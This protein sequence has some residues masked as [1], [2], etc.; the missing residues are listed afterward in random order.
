MPGRH[1]PARVLMAED[2]I[3]DVELL[4]DELRE[5]GFLFE[6]RV[7][8]DE[9]DFCRELEEFKPHLVLSDLTMPGFSGYRALDLVRASAAHVPFIF[10]S[11]TIGE[12]AAIEA[13]KRGATDFVL[14]NNLARLPS[15]VR[16]A[17][18]DFEER[19]FARA[20]RIRTGAR[21]AI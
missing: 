5:D 8:D 14:K 1:F 10:V 21:P 2:D 13:L 17:F 3:A 4:A 18:R 15:V 7:V 19:N 11:G 12:E 16:R 9:A 20:H 6:H